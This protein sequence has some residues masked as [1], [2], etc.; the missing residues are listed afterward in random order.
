MFISLSIRQQCPHGRI[1]NPVKQF[2][3]LVVK[4]GNKYRDTANPAWCIGQYLPSFV[5]TS[6]EMM[7][8]GSRIMNVGRSCTPDLESE[9]ARTDWKYIGR[10]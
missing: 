10:K 6:P 5:I 4:H 2:A 1:R 7:A 9:D 3:E 8:K